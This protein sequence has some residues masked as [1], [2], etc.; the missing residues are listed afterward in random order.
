[1]SRRGNRVKVVGWRAATEARIALADDR[2][3]KLAPVIK[4]LPA[5]GVTSLSG[6]ATAL[7]KRGVLT[8]RG[9]GRWHA[10]QVARGLKRLERDAAEHL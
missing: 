6:I 3:A 8:P 4:A 1:M 2:G 9:R 5:N 10:A 7:N